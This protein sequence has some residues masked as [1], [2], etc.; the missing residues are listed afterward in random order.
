MNTHAVVDADG[1][2]ERLICPPDG[3]SPPGSFRLVELATQVKGW[4]E[5]P[6]NGA[7]L[8]CSDAGVL[9]WHDPRTPAERDAAEWAAAK[10]QRRIEEFG[11]FVFDG[12]LYQSD[13]ASQLRIA[14]IAAAAR[15]DPAFEV[16]FVRADN[17]VA[18]L[19]AR[20]CQRLHAALATHVLACHS[21]AQ[22][23]R[24]R[25]GDAP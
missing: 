6:F 21:R 7:W 2:V 20:A 11:G 3:Y 23:R 17:T 5:P 14:H 18:R 25:V 22:L 13:E 10:A 24:P 16:D 9:S 15:L 8:A 19:D 12:D 4:P 1:F